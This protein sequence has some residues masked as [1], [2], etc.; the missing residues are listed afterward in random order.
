MLTVALIGPDG[1][2]KTTI[3]RQLEETM[4]LPSKY[5]YMGVNAE[6]S[7]IA[8]PTSRLLAACRKFLGRPADKGGPLDHARANVSPKGSVR[9]LVVS[10]KRL[11]LLANQVADE[12]YRQFVVAWYRLRG[13]LVILDRDFYADYYAYDVAK[14]TEKSFTRRLHGF[15]LRRCYR[16]PD[17]F[18]FLDADPQTMFDRKGEGTLSLLEQRRQDYL[19][20]K[21]VVEHFEVVDANQSLHAVISDVKSCIDQALPRRAR[22]KRPL[23][24]EDREGA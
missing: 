23:M 12:F 17:L 2:G 14:G 19:A 24:V 6:A 10:T 21:N 18:L 16:R 5:V 4:S 22:H 3:A 9:R 15:V 20:L 13:H 7:N 1:V 11:L 8:L